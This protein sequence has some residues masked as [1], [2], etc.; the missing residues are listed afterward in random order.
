MGKGKIYMGEMGWANDWFVGF[1]GHEDQVFWELEVVED[2]EY[3]VFCPNVE[4]IAVE[5]AV[6]SE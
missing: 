6:I 5:A 1:E 2:V 4:R 3:E